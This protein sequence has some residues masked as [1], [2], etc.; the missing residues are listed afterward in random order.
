MSEQART[1]PRAIPSGSLVNGMIPHCPQ[2]DNAAVICFTLV[3]A[4]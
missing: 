1:V 4:A 3:V 2:I